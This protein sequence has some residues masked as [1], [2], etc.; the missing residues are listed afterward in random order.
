LHASVMTTDAWR[1]TSYSPRI[2][3]IRIGTSG[4]T[5]KA[6]GMTRRRRDF[7]AVYNMGSTTAVGVKSPRCRGNSSTDWHTNN[8]I[9]RF[10]QRNN[11]L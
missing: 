9:I 4:R 7:D 3:I 8:N 5:T 1:K 10:L 11:I 2:I 6:V